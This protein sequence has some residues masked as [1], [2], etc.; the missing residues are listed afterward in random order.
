MFRERQGDCSRRGRGRFGPR[1][2]PRPDI[3]PALQPR[4]LRHR[5][6]RTTPLQLRTPADLAGV[7]VMVFAPHPDDETTFTGAIIR[8][9]AE[10]GA[11][12]S[13]VI[14]TDGSDATI[15]DP[16]LATMENY[17]NQAVLRSGEL[18]RACEPLGCS[19]W[20][21]LGHVDSGMVGSPRS[22]SPLAFTNLPD[23]PVV[24]E[25]VAAIRRFR[26]HVVIMPPP[27]GNY[28]HPDH[29]A[30]YRR[31][32]LAVAA[33]ADKHQ[34]K[35]AGAPLVV[36]KV[37]ETVSPF[38]SAPTASTIIDGRASWAWVVRAFRAHASQMPANWEPLALPEPVARERFGVQS[39]ERVF[40]EV[41]QRGSPERSLGDG[42]RIGLTDRLAF[43]RERHR[44]ER[45]QRGGPG[46]GLAA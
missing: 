22:K 16:T 25:M 10:R 29:I 31:A 36:A 4:P 27:D 42:L 34:F 9:A 8:D 45:L 37:Y 24:G 32:S 21:W 41:R 6:Q 5:N 40:P 39:L 30:T 38:R 33:A 2:I 7:R 15:F 35:A 11:I 12:V 46:R 1:S 23:E 44:L 14:A 26:P 43:R 13:V 17:L 19:E 20:E 28:G 3:D 18:D